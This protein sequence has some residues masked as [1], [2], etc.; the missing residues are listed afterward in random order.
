MK[1][2]PSTLTQFQKTADAVAATT[3][4]TEKVRLISELLSSLALPD[5]SLAAQYLTGRTFPQHEERVV[6]IGGNSLARAVAEAAGR[7]E[8]SLGS[9][10]RKHGDLGDM[11]KALLEK[12]HT[13]SALNLESVAALFDNLSSARAPAQKGELLRKAFAV[14]SADDVKYIVKILTGD[15]RIGSKESLVEQG[16]AKA[17]GRDADAVRRANMTL[18]DIGETLRLAAQDRLGSAKV[19]LFHPLGFM[20]ATPV[21]TAEELFPD[22]D[23]SAVYIEYKFDGIR[24]QAHKN[25]AGKVKIFSRTLDEIV[26]FPELVAPLS[27]LP[28][29]LILDGEILGWRDDQPLPFTE[30]QPR[31]GRKQIDMWLQHDIPVRFMVFD[32]LFQDGRLLLDTPLRERKDRLH[33]LFANTPGSIALANTVLCK[34]AIA[35]NR[36]F[37]AALSAGHEGLVAKITDSIYTPGRRGGSWLKLKEP[38]ATLDVVVTA[39]EYGHGKRH[40]VLSDLTFAVRD[41]ERLLNIGKAYSGLTDAEITE[42]TAF[43]LK[44]TVEDQGFRRLVEPRLVL[45][46]A[47][48]NMQRS[49]RHESG[50]ALRF[51]RILRTRPDKPVS[52]IDTLARAEELFAKQIGVAKDSHKK[53]K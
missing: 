14:A 16:I 36:E 44:H 51:P 17:F 13:E 35:V 37:R 32:V 38:Y 20:L 8:E 6:G 26:E 34:D 30:L 21:E 10:Y 29:E 49:K 27:A 18:G 15:L 24:A 2:S 4:K 7:A 43:F 11:A 53:A 28:G 12:S 45:E 41:G 1:S 33:E 52:E 40:K 25:A 5:A 3:K 23:T 22:A 31:L 39:A 48:N 46:V 19:R 47:F 50:L 9:A 42:N